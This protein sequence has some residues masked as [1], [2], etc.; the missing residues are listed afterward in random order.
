MSIGLLRPAIV[1]PDAMLQ[2][3]RGQPLLCEAPEGPFR[4]A[5]TEGWSGTAPFSAE[6][7]E[8]QLQAVLLHEMAHIAR[9]DHWVGVGQRIAGLLFW[10]N[11]L[12][13]GIC[14]EISDLREEICDN[15]VV[16]VQGEGQR[17]ARILVGLA[18]RVTTGPLLPS[19]I[20]VMEP[21][22]AGLTGRVSRL[23][24]KER[25]METRIDFRSML[26]LFSCGIAVLTAMA[27]VGGLQLV[28]A[29]SAGNS[30]ARRAQSGCRSQ[31]RRKDTTAQPTAS[32]RR[33]SW[34][35]RRGWRRRSL[36]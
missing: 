12:V 9:R 30:T 26:L 21:R 7:D 10:W 8:E 33:G 35:T 11:P 6:A 28:Y 16:L 20:G 19:A 14:D 25:N 24:D 15:H 27:T 18:A 17:L 36:R 29:K 4:R 1:L 31:A 13:H 3:K 5:P 2:R 23:L 34:A 32:L 22:L